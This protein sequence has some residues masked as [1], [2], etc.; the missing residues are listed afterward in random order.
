MRFK[1]WL[2][3]CFTSFAFFFIVFTLLYPRAEVASAS[4]RLADGTQV[5]LT[6]RITERGWV[7]DANG[8]SLKV[9]TQAGTSAAASATTTLERFGARL[10][11]GDIVLNP[12]GTI[13]RGLKAGDSATF[14]W[15]ASAVLPGETSAVLWF[16]QIGAN[17]DDYALYAKQF[18]F[19]AQDYAGLNPMWTRLGVGLVL[20]I[21]GL[22][23]WSDVRK[24]KRKP[25]SKNAKNQV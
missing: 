22:L 20:V 10:E 14:N 15:K 5:N 19:S 4:V 1:F 23:L 16:Y 25:L 12:T 9:I 17:G 21:G 18:T 13:E 7:G 6:A 11:M 24:K 8:F 2:G 3:L